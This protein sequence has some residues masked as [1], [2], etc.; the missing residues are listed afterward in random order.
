[1]VNLGMTYT[2]A[3]ATDQEPT[4]AEDGVQDVPLTIARP[5]LTRLIEELLE[6]GQVSALTVRG[7]R[8]AYLVAPGSYERSQAVGDDDPVSLRL[9]RDRMNELVNDPVLGKRLEE[10][11]PDLFLLL[12]T[13]GF[14]YS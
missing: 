14:G 3:M 11:D 10:L 7:R 8:R 6:K 12:N 13:G 2:L 5:L 4:L 9:L 1:M